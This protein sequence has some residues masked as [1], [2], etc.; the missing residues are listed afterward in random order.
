MSR[1]DDE[2]DLAMLGYRQRLDRSLGAWSSSAVSY[3]WVAILCGVTAMFFF[4]FA[5]AGP[6][7]FWRPPTECWHATD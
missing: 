6:A 1:T 2:R 5:A 3:G 7:F 4:G